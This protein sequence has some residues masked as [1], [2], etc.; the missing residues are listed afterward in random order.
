MQ[1][2]VVEG[3]ATQS[4]KE[5]LDKFSGLGLPGS[6][7]KTL[8]KMKD[9]ASEQVWRSNKKQSTHH[10]IIEMSLHLM[11]IF[12]QLYQSE[13]PSTQFCI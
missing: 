11:H 13:T 5:T 7:T 4:S 9:E 3:L 10:L 2:R 12:V 8:W 1:R 6:F